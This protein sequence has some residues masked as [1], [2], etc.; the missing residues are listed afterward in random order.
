M[1]D[2]KLDPGFEKF[3]TWCKQ[4]GVPVVIVSR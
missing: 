1:L 3:Y 4:N 2:I